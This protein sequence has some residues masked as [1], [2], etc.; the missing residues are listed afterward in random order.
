MPALLVNAVLNRAVAGLSIAHHY[1][2]RR[3]IAEGCHGETACYGVKALRFLRHGEA[4]GRLTSNE[5][6]TKQRQMRRGSS[7]LLQSSWLIVRRLL[8]LHRYLGDLASELVI[9]FL[10]FIRHG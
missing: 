1:R 4:A 8:Q 6:N 5:P 9:A 10:V 2:K 3:A 7:C